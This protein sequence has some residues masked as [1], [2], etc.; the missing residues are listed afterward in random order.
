ML[1]AGQE[2][3]ELGRGDRLDLLAQPVERV[4]MNAREEAAVAP[5]RTPVDAHAQHDACGF[6]VHE[7]RVVAEDRAQRFHPAPENGLRLAC[8]LRREPSV[9]FAGDAALHGEGVEPLRP[10]LPFFDRHVAHPEE[11]LVHL[12]RVR[13]LRPG[14]LAHARDGV[15]IQRAERVRGLRVERA[16]RHHGLGA[17][18]LEGRVVQ[19]RVG[20][21][22]EDAARER[23]RLDGVDGPALDAAV[24][25]GLDDLE[26]PVHVHRFGEAV[27]DGLAHDRVI[28]RHFDRSAR[29][30]LRAGQD[31]RERAREQVVRAHAQERGRDLLA[32]ARAL[33]HERALR[34]PA[35]ARLEHRRGQER[36]DQGLAGRGRLQVVEDLA[37]LEAVLR[38]QGEH[39]GFLVRRRLQL[40]AE[41]HAELLA[42]GQSP[43]AVDLGPEGRVQDELHAAALVE[44]ALQ[45]D[46]L[47][48]RD[49]AQGLAS[50]LH[51]LRDLER[52]PFRQGRTTG[53]LQESRGRVLAARL[54]AQGRD[55]R[56]Q[57]A[58]AAGR[59][60]EPE[61]QRRWLALGV[62]HADHSRRH[63]Q[64]APRRVAELEDVAP[65][66]FDRPV[67]VDR[68]HQ[69]P[70]RLLP[71][72]VV[73][74]V[75]D[76]APG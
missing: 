2:V 23:R 66:G 67:L 12:F 3:Q 59:L 9:A 61:R 37:Q 45:H 28:H 56:G 20:L 69:R 14:F 72:L 64:D 50:R 31:L 62:G 10:G 65:V 39:D 19:E 27:L 54:L 53:G 76:R 32:V 43:G 1:P 71:D 36:L 26:E 17:P 33:Q 4:A 18:L 73:R 70:F 47:L 44:E 25:Q 24:L 46:P 58:R 48:R 75:G 51:V 63:A 30:R 40:E 35:P 5:G 41:A 6:E 57:L 7:Q 38:A 29:Q 34:V 55:L 11:G 8:R 16:S 21:G 68:P 60:A 13:G 15:R 74:G 22:G 52:R 42:Q 49:G